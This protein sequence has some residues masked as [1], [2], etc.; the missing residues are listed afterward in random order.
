MSDYIGK[1]VIRF[2]SGKNGCR[3][4]GQC[5]NDWGGSYGTNQRILRYGIAIE[6]LK[7]YFSEL[8]SV[9]ALYF[10]YEKGDIA[11]NAH[12]GYEYCSSPDEVKSAWLQAVEWVGKEKFEAIEHA[13]II[14]KYYNVC[15]KEL[16][17]FFDCEKNRGFQ[18]MVFAGSIFNGAVAYANRIK[19]LLH[20]YQNDEQFVDT[21]YNS[22]YKEYPWERWADSKNVS[23]IENSERELVRSLLNE[24]PFK[25]GGAEASKK[26]KVMIDAGHFGSYYN[27]SPC[28]SRYYESNFT[29][30][31]SQRLKTYLEEYNIQADFTRNN[32]EQDV[33]LVERGQ[34]AKGY[35]FL[36]SMHSNAVGESGKGQE[37]SI[38]YPVAYCLVEDDR[39]SFDEVSRQIGLKLAKGVQEVL[40]TKQDGIVYMWKA[41][42]DRDGDGQLNDNYLGVLHGARIAQTAAVILEH[43][44]HTNTAI[45]KK[46]LQSSYVDA[47]AKKDAQVIAE[48]FGAYK[49]ET[50]SMTSFA[51]C[52]K[53]VR[54]IADEIPVYK[55]ATLEEKSGVLKVGAARRAVQSF[56]LSNNKKGLRLEDGSYINAIKG[57]DVTRNS[58]TEKV[59]KVKSPDGILNVRDFPNSYGSAVLRILANGNL[60]RVVGECYN[61]SDHW[62]LVK[63]ENE[64]ENITG[65]VAAR[66]LVKV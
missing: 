49:K 62:Y 37:E 15:K 11:T 35:D 39:F 23:Y 47:L 12:P 5:G 24:P 51:L 30:D 14:E 33:G 54:V 64:T 36:I 3:S 22:L 61:N 17:G 53:T 41:D 34:K 40:Q 56:G 32:K 2:E 25:E 1:Y 48:F 57:V 59:M 16:D 9:R 31:I 4:F 58:M 43:S 60:V 8:D 20:T 19:N 10:N 50:V 46:L 42:W 18:E 63:I 55:D 29:W 38:D 66:Y 27:Q 26:I 52:D 6:F 45:T 13:D 44:F 21:V 7:T 28:D 65:F